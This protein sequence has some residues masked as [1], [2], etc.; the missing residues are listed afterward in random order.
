[1]KSAECVTTHQLNR[2]VRKRMALERTISSHCCHTMQR[3]EFREALSLLFSTLLEPD[4]R[5][6][7]FFGGRRTL[8]FEVSDALA[9]ALRFPKD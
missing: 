1:M 8:S 6:I 5:S 4:H 3:L 7:V 2:L 9:T